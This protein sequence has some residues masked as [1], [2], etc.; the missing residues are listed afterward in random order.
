MPLRTDLKK[1]LV[2][3]SGPIVIGQAAEFDYAGTQ[4]CTAL[5]EEGLE[6][7]LVNS[8]PATIMT[9]PDM[10]DRIYIE[11]L[12]VESVSQIIRCERPQGIV[13]TLGGQTGLNMA[14][15]LARAGI[16]DECQVELLGT[17]LSSIEEAEDREKFRTLCN[18]IGE[19]VPESRIVTSWEEAREFAE[20]IG[21]PLIIR[22][23]YTLGGT[24]GGI[25]SDWDSFQSIVAL[26]L[27][28]SPVHQ[29][30]VERSVAGF[31]EIEY[32]VMR[33][34]DDTCIVVCNMENVDAVGVHTGDSIVVA[35]SQTLSDQEY[36]L[37]RSSAL[38][39]IRE[40]KIEG[41]CNV[42]Y[43]LDPHSF[44]YYV[45]EVNPRV[46]RSSALAS[47]ATGYPI[48]K[49]AAKIAIGYR[50]DELKNPITGSTYAAFEPALDYVV[51]KIPRWPFDKFTTA[52]RKLGTQMKATGEVMAIDR[53][54]EA[55]L[56]KAIRS[57]EIG[58]HTLHVK[59]VGQL[60]DAQLTER[61]QTPDDE[62]L[63]LV[64]EAFRRGYDLE[65]LH[66]LTSIDQFFLWK[67]QKLVTFEQ[68]L[69]A[70][71]Q[72]GGAAALTRQTLREA[73]RLG[74]TDAWLAQVTGLSF[75]EV[76][77]LR[78]SNGLQPVYKIVDTCAAE[79][80]AR[81]P[82]YYSTYETEDEVLK[83]DTDS[84]VVLGSGPIR[85]GQGIEFD[86]A[87]VHAAWA[88]RRAGLKS[89][90]INNNPETVSTD[91][92]TADRLYFEPLHLEDVLNVIDREQPKGVV[93]QFGGQTAINLAEPLAKRGIQILGT[94]LD[95]ID[96]A[97]DRKRF[98]R[99]LFDLKIPRPEGQTVT[100]LTEAVDV[101]RSLGF[102][103]LVRP[104]YVL[105]GRAM[106][107]VYAEE[108][109]HSYMEQAVDVSPE[110][111][112]LI[113]RY[114]IG[115]EAE[116][117]AVS[118][119]E[120]VLIPGMMEH[121][122]RAGVHS[123]D[124]IAV[125]PTQN[126]PADVIDQMEDYTVRLSRALNIKGLINIQFVIARGVAYVI[127]VNPR[128][129]RTVPFLS[130]VTGVPMVELATR[131]AL[132][133]SL[134]DLGYQ[135]G[136][137]PVSELIAVK[138][139][140]FSFSKLRKVDITLG[141]EM[142]ST[143]EVM[144]RDQ[145]YAKALYKGLIAAGI[146]IP[147]H[148]TILATIANKDK[149]ESLPLLRRYHQLGYRI[150]A[151]KGTAA[152]LRDNGLEAHEVRKLSEG[153]ENVVD[154][155][156]QGRAH[157]VINTLT[158]GLE[159]TRD[160]FRIRRESVEYGVPCFTSLDTA[161]AVLEVLESRAVTLHPLETSFQL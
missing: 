73:K 47:K 6:V 75:D 20:E 120:T 5:R 68:Q 9:D 23:A 83:D 18:R 64:F 29:V 122:E 78:L 154:A 111:P 45:I 126:L 33:D 56:Q 157:M 48:A 21:F 119:G 27:A 149:E 123:G 143:G 113:D 61:L 34:K 115:V 87:S 159:P 91:F 82:Y 147:E 139:P 137:H 124:S 156:H 141:P 11:P 150:M 59:G 40:L 12:T 3:G 132:G 105:G 158:R 69:S 54:F 46:S 8:N 80:E 71:G 15:G 129:S 16:L 4:A 138:V 136:V 155:I 72:A 38:R 90:I 99:L 49:M 50:L 42:Q 13:A 10:A 125:Y 106:Q 145:T 109:L 36:Q 135:T 58:T 89:I 19:P 140:V 14:V 41:G 67:F 74:F 30:L 70:A 77:S 95:S 76:R 85:I 65:Q 117:D 43:A 92:N 144:G 62:R 98:D 148:G 103:L 151:T 26:G 153:A 102:P 118:D 79:F 101:A 86:Y 107:I 100:T 37:L 2:I 116:V 53:S 128:S 57:L 51:T 121:V 60:T 28:L 25:G 44:N 110:R 130:K 94:S 152:F 127:E 133:E 160:G 81:T 31:K 63:F 66:Q 131:V 32:E 146:R 7:V 104:S 22:P 142:K 96:R 88:I 114:I 112:I 55:S 84:V 108:E 24:G 39:L 35:P 17:P 134:A 52:N 161:K 1:V 97:E 93:V